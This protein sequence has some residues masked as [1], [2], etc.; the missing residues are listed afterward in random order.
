MDELKREKVR[1]YL[2]KKLMFMQ[3]IVEKSRI[4][5]KR[6]ASVADLF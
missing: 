5:V 3:Q 1:N 6:T 2:K 4:I